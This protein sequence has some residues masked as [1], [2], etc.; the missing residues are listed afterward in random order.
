M[1]YPDSAYTGINY[2]TYLYTDSN[3]CSNWTDDYITVDY[4]TGIENVNSIDNILVYPNPTSGLLT[5]ESGIF[6]KKNSLRIYNVTEQLMPVDVGT[7]SGNK[8]TLDAS[9]LPSGVYF[10]E[11][12]SEGKMAHASFIR[13]R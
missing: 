4:C 12:I 8:I 5:I 3:N 7:T 1:F 13:A 11:F 10:I 9:S 6:N 2:I